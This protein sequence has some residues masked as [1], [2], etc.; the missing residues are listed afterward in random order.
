MHHHKWFVGISEAQQLSI[1]AQPATVL[2]AFQEGSDE[3]IKLRAVRAMRGQA[4]VGGT[5]SFQRLEILWSRGS[6]DIEAR[7]RHVTVWWPRTE[8]WIEN[9]THNQLLACLIGCGLSECVCVCVCF[10]LVSSLVQGRRWLFGFL[11]WRW[12]RQ[13]GKGWQESQ[14]QSAEIWDDLHLLSSEKA[15]CSKVQPAGADM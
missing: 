7:D 12:G 15:R 11:W 3:E 14:G 6:S 1:P 8:S 10:G 5:M 9:T 2:P 13:R 4:W